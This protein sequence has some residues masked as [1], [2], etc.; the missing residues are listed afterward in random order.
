MPDLEQT[1]A[2]FERAVA[3]TPY[4]VHRTAEG[5]S[6]A[7]EVEMPG[8]PEVSIRQG[9]EVE[10]DPR[11]DVALTKPFAQ[12]ISFAGG[13]ASF[14]PMDV[15]TVFASVLPTDQ[16][17]SSAELA[18]IQPSNPDAGTLQ[19]LVD[20]VLVAQ[21]WRTHKSSRVMLRDYLFL[22]IVVLVVIFAMVSGLFALMWWYFGY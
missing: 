14:R 17:R 15:K 18:P 9:I 8:Q 20:S 3:G 2:G 22:W 5:L 21:G 19:R 12:Q 16:F 11:G 4:R 6:V 13:Q 1:L 10:L 7:A